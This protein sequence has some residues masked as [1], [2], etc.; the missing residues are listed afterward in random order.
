MIRW[1]LLTLLV[2]ENLV[3]IPSGCYSGSPPYGDPSYPPEPPW[4]E[5][6]TDARIDK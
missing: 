3:L 2:A 1:I 5:T 6:V 4:T